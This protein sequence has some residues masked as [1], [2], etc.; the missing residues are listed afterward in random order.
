MTLGGI[1]DCVESGDT[2]TFQVKDDAYQTIN[3]KQHLFRLI[4]SLDGPFDEVSASYKTG[5]RVDY[6]AYKNVA[7]LIEHMM[8]DFYEKQFC[9]ILKVTLTQ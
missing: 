5:A 9:D 3:Q 8:A 7:A 1:L 6:N 2:V 4:K